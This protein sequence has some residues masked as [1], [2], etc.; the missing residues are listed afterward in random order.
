[1]YVM[2]A[3]TGL[4][5]DGSFQP[6]G[7]PSCWVRNEAAVGSFWTATALITCG[8][9][10]ARMLPPPARWKCTYEVP[11]PPRTTVDGVTDQAKPRRGPRLLRS[12]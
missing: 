11:Y 12:G 1:M 3:A 5:L 9:L 6:I 10:M 2:L 4:K 7:K 8:P